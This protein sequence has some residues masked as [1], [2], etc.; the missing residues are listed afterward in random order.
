M[1]SF[2]L[3]K[4]R[5]CCCRYCTTVFVIFPVAVM[6]STHLHVICQHFH[7]FYVIFQGQVDCRNFT[8]TRPLKNNLQLDYN[9]LSYSLLL[10]TLLIWNWK[11][12]VYTLWYNSNV[13]EKIVTYSILCKASKLS[14]E[15]KSIVFV[16]LVKS[17]TVFGPLP[18]RQKNINT[19]CKYNPK[20][21]T[22]LFNLIW[23]KQLTIIRSLYLE[24]VKF[25]H[26]VKCYW[27]Q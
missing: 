13:H 18:I 15:S 7:L 26:L 12:N 19:A 17:F 25:D 21:K 23:S 6:V 5:P 11:T 24:W 20:T 2:R 9:N 22:L 3:L 8:L 1:Q 10:P 14:A 16:W 4:R 27:H